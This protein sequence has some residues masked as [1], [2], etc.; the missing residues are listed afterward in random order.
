MSLVKDTVTPGSDHY[1]AK[2]ARAKIGSSAER[3]TMFCPAA[4]TA[5]R[6]T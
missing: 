1:N 3:A 2:A 4:T 6:P 5:A